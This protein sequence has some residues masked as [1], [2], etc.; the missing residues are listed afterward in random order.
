LAQGHHAVPGDGAFDLDDG[1]GQAQRSEAR[2]DQVEAAALMAEADRAD[3]GQNSGRPTA[4]EAVGEDLYDSA[5]R[6]KQLAA[7]LE[8]SADAETLQARLLAD[9]NQG[10]PAAEAV[11]GKT[12]RAPKP[13]KKRVPARGLGEHHTLSR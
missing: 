10:R 12:V 8:G 4:T 7:R 13:R 6:R 9:R 3:Q 2:R 1:E 5:E 11:A